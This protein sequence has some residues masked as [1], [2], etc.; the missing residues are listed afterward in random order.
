LREP[1][2]GKT[3]PRVSLHYS[4]AICFAPSFADSII[5]LTLTRLVV[6]IIFE[7]F[8]F[9]LF[10]PPLGDYHIRNPKGV[11]LASTRAPAKARS[12]DGLRPSRNY[13]GWESVSTFWSTRS[14]IV[15]SGTDCTVVS[16][17]RATSR[18]LS[19][20]ALASSTCSG[21][22][23]RG[24]TALAFVSNARS[25]PDAP[26]VGA[27]GTS[28]RST[29][30]EARPPAWPWL[31]RLLLRWRGRGRGELECCSSTTRGRCRRFRRRRAGRRPPLSLSRGGGRSIMS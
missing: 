26:L 8:S 22:V 18:K 29:A 10:T 19:T 31:P 9:A 15:T 4:L 20:S 2:L 3:N 27:L 14:D 7:N 11:A 25:T 21:L 28:I 17:T 16:G 30:D 13:V 6:V 5:F 23:C 12:L 1:N 24:G